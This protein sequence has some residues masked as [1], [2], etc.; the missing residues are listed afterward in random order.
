MSPLT[1]LCLR[2]G[3]WVLHGL[4]QL[5]QPFAGARVVLAPKAL[6]PPIVAPILRELLLAEQTPTFSPALPVYEALRQALHDATYKFPELSY[7]IVR[8]ELKLKSYVV[9]T[10]DLPVYALAM[11]VSLCIRFGW[12]YANYTPS[13][14]QG[15]RV[16][17]KEKAASAQARGYLRLLNVSTGVS[18]ASEAHLRDHSGASSSREEPVPAPLTAEELLTRHV[19]DVDEELLR[20]EQLV[21]DNIDVMGTMDLVEFWSEAGSPPTLSGSFKY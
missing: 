14:C 8:A 12:T 16:S 10:R 3:G 5:P 21:W 15:F 20:C 13:Q 6:W 7:A 11:V 19:S 2:E 17:V 1:F 18:H 4:Q 9:K